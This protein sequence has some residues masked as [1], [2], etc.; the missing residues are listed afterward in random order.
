MYKPN[1]IT[2]V[3]GFLRV[4]FVIYLSHNL[5]ELGHR[6]LHLTSDLQVISW[7]SKV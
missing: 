1:L 4:S 7:H 3:T 2:S 5:W 6:T